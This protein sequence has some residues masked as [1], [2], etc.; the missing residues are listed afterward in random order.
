MKLR[1]QL[2]LLL[3]HPVI[4]VQW[5]HSPV[6]R[7]VKYDWYDAMRGILSR[8]FLAPSLF[9]LWPTW[10][11]FLLVVL[12]ARFPLFASFDY[13]DAVSGVFLDL[14]TLFCG[15]VSRK[16]VWHIGETITPQHTTSMIPKNFESPHSFC[17]SRHVRFSRFDFLPMVPK[18]P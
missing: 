8:L 15:D 14:K 13:C 9:C 1:R 16:S 10:S 6:P 4:N 18:V 11:G 17:L 12:C 5:R 7:C 2:G 3:I